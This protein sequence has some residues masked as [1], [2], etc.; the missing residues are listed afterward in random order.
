M[1]LNQEICYVI[2]CYK[3]LP[4]FCYLCGKLGRH[5]RECSD[6]SQGILNEENWRFG[7]WMQALA[8]FGGRNKK[9]S[10]DSSREEVSA[11]GTF[12]GSAGDQAKAD[13]EGFREVKQV[14]V[15]VGKNKESR[16]DLQVKQH[17]SDMGGRN[18][19]TAGINESKVSSFTGK[20]VVFMSPK[21]QVERTNSVGRSE[22]DFYSVD[23]LQSASKKLTDKSSAVNSRQE[24]S[25]FVV[26][27]IDDTVEISSP[28]KKR[29]KRIA[30][31]K[32]TCRHI[33]DFED[34]LG[35]RAADDPVE[36]EG[37]DLQ[38]N[39]RCKGAETPSISAMAGEQHR[40]Q[41]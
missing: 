36:E 38:G 8:P 34:G 2:L 1:C 17:V 31:D 25:T 41:P 35:K 10:D 22:T 21:Q 9:N 19:N 32:S 6:N 33:G 7:A 13:T 18:S 5:V 3:K 16:A 23:T 40:R 20:G 11:G 37:V 27:L 14:V 39:K 30:R 12:S 15:D 4:N 29:W 28:R 24:D 26:N